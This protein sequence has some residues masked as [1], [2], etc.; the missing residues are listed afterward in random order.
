MTDII[1][2]TYK[3][4]DVMDESSLIKDMEK[5][6][7][8]LEKNTYILER[9]K[10]YNSI[11]NLEEKINIKKE[12]YSNKDYKCYMKC[13]NELSLIVLKIDKQYKKYTSTKVH[14]C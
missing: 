8:R 7:K 11:D 6:K 2:S 1:A 12:L 9:V 10:L 3:L 13:Y 4:L 14:N 5:Y